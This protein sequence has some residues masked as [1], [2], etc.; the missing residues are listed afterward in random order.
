MKPR[1][2][3]SLRYSAHADRYIR[4]D[5]RKMFNETNTPSVTIPDNQIT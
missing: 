2:L 1:K 5:F 3:E 4:T